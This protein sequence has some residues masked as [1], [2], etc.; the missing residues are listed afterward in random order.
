MGKGL[1]VDIKGTLGKFGYS[2]IPE[3]MSDYILKIV[4][5]HAHYT[6]VKKAPYLAGHEIH[7]RDNIQK[8]IDL[9]TKSGAVFIKLADIPYAL[10]AEY[11]SKKRLAHPYMK[12][13]ASAARAKLKAVIRV[14]FKEAVAEEKAKN[15]N[16]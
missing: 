16:S 5:D 7:L 14:A 12:P 3:E 2:N 1:Y 8:E 6:A 11:G 10:V 4:V 9:K 13:A 15:G